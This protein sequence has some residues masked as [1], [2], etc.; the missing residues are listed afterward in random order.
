MERENC[1]SENILITRGLIKGKQNKSLQ[2][3]RQI[4]VDVTHGGSSVD[5]VPAAQD[6][7]GLCIIHPAGRQ[8]DKRAGEERT[9]GLTEKSLFKKIN[10]LKKS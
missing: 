9:L 4:A 8:R 7:A 3:L 1:N 5:F 6:E 10:A 2:L